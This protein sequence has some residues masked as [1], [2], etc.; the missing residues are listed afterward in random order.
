MADDKPLVD[1]IGVLQA[2]TVDK[3]SS[4]FNILHS[5]YQSALQGLNIKVDVMVSKSLEDSTKHKA[6]PLLIRIH[7]G[8]LVTGSSLY[9]P[10]FTN[11]ILDYARHSGAVLVSPNYRLM[12]ESTGSDILEDMDAFWCWL[13]HGGV[14]DILEQGG[15]QYLRI[16]LDRTLLVGESAGGYLAMQLALSYHG[17]VRGLIA[18]YP[19]LDIIDRHYTEPY[20]KPIIKVANRPIEVLECHLETLR[21]ARAEG[22]N[23][24]VTEADP[25]DRMELSFC[26]VQNGRYLDFF[27]TGPRGLFPMDRITD[28][29]DADA[30][31]EGAELPPMFI[32]HGEQDSAVPAE[33]SQRFVQALRKNRPRARVHLEIQPGD[34]GFDFSA[35]LQTDWLKQGL[36]VVGPAWLGS[37]YGE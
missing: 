13:R 36:K 1:L 28:S 18:A 6:R 3:Y 19:M 17:Q 24:V 25:P 33:G 29:Q 26:I 31:S 30:A 21:A 4:F 14:D 34:H 11:W 10:W 37:E 27:G 8:Y 32:F 5:T 35:T 15:Y 16:D 9:P 7:G 22:R 20:S 12:P 23:P 2:A